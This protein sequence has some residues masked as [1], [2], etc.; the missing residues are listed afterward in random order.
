MER[1]SRGEITLRILE[2]MRA[3]TAAQD[4]VMF[5]DEKLPRCSS[6]LRGSSHCARLCLENTEKYG[7]ND[8]RW[9]AD[10]QAI[11][12]EALQADGLNEDALSD[13]WRIFE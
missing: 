13:M 11:Y 2:N 12:E 8:S 7:Y 5:R 3:R 9:I 4:V 6:M 1:V 10:C